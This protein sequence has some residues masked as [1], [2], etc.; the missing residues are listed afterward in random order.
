MGSGSSLA[1]QR[2]SREPL[3][4]ILGVK[5]G[6]DALPLRHRAPT[7]RAGRRQRAR[8]ESASFKK[9]PSGCAE[10][11]RRGRTTTAR[12]VTDVRKGDAIGDSS[13]R[14][15]PGKYDGTLQE[16]NH[17]NNRIARILSGNADLW[18]PVGPPSFATFMCEPS[19][20]P[21]VDWDLRARGSQGEAGC[22]S[23]GEQGASQQL[24]L[25]QWRDS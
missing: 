7:Q 5:V 6:D 15:S 2:L 21:C 22:D 14:W 13:G 17:K 1:F 3:P 11:P 8:G 18:L 12:P 23:A 4:F 10:G 25:D 19:V 20:V 9:A 16:M 24:T